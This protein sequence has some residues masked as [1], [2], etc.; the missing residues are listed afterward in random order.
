MSKN[1]TMGEIMEVLRQEF[2]DY[3][4]GSDFESFQS[5]H[6]P[7]EFIAYDEQSGAEYIARDYLKGYAQSWFS[8]ELEDAGYWDED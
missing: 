4:G 6:K 2:G 1:T 7:Q 5:C 3:L 8:V